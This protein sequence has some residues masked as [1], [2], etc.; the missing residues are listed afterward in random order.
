MSTKFGFKQEKSSIAPLDTLDQKRKTSRSWSGLIKSK[1]STH[2]Q[3]P[4]TPPISEGSKLST[5]KQNV[6]L[7]KSMEQTFHRLRSKRA[8]AA[9]VEA[10][11][12]N[13]ISAQIRVLRQQRG[14]NQKELAEKIGT[15]QG[16]VSRLEDASYGRYSIKTLLDLSSIFDI[17][18]FVRF[19]PFS[20]SIPATWDTRPEKLE[21]ESFEDEIDRIRFVSKSVERYISQ[22]D[23]P[24]ELFEVLRSYSKAELDSYNLSTPSLS[25]SK[26]YETLSSRW[27]SSYLTKTV[28]DVNGEL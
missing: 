12:V 20:Q 2:L 22:V 14:W 11:L 28:N 26:K 27:K 8:R 1:T 24:S 10:E 4:L 7:S 15:T 21:V 5:V 3:K 6:L 25:S 17:S 19:M 16:V 9:Y 18:L 13:G 23:P